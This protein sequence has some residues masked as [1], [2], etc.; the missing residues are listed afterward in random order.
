MRP[1]LAALF[2]KLTLRWD[3]VNLAKFLRGIRAELE[4]RAV[5][6]QNDGLETKK[7]RA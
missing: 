5:E 4:R 7:E 1:L 6:A 3:T 2:L